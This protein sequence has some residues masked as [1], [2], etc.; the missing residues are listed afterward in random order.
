MKDH[1]DRNTRRRR[2]APIGLLGGV[3]ALALSLG[4][5]V[6][7]IASNGLLTHPRVHAAQGTFRPHHP[8]DPDRN[9]IL[10]IGT[11]ARA[12]DPLG[13][14]DVLCVASIDEKNHR[15]ELLSIPRDTQVAFPDG[16]YHKINDALMQGGPELT[17][18]VVE[19]LIGLPVDHYA[20]TRFDGLVHLINRIGGVPID[21]PRRLHYIT[22]DT[23]HG[24]IDLKP[25]R[26]QLN[27]E[28]ALGFVRFRHDALGDIGRTAR[29][30]AF[31]V[32]LKTQ[33]LRPETIPKIPG[34]ISDLASS[35]ETD[36]SVIE[37]G[38]LASRAKAY[39][40]YDTIHE[41]LPGSFHN[42]EPLDS[43]DLSYWVVN[44]KQA[45]FVAKQF[46]EDGIVQS[47]PIQ[48]PE[49]TRDWV[50][51]QEPNAL[52]QNSTSTQQ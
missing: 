42:P 15:M 50:Y 39:A 44:P 23:T 45:R 6:A 36:M 46:F 34:M 5:F 16:R 3:I 37:V 10:L 48:D 9:T 31:L 13:N 28:Q 47:N 35:M 29:Q 8:T 4:L 18:R 17:A 27:G 1:R 24:V 51:P 19:N 21:V 30:Q 22:G 49:Q 20:I 12:G 26:Q 40:T 52:H 41:T 43:D 2:R 14:S 25:G 11:D 32:A 38:K 33:L 7:F